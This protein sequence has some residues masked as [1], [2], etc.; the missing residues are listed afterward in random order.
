VD[1][2]SLIYP[3]WVDFAPLY[4]KA[5]AIAHAYD[6][7]NLVFFLGSGISK[8]YAEEMPNWEQLLNILLNKLRLKTR[9]QREEVLSLLGQ[10]KYLVAAEAIKRYAITDVSNRDVAVDQAIAE[11]LQQRLKRSPN[12]NP[13]V[14]LTLMDFSVP[15]FTT[16]YDTIVEDI[17]AEHNVDTYSRVAI[18]YEDETAAGQ[19][20]SPTQKSENFVFKLHGSIGKPGRL[21]FDE[22]DYFDFYFQ[23]KW[24]ISLELL[25]HTLATKMV[26][27]IGFSLSDPEIMLILREATRYSSSYQHVALMLE[28]EVNPIEREILRS[29]YKVDP[30]LYNDHSLLPLFVMEMR[31]FYRQ[32]GI[33]FRIKPEAANLKKAVEV[34]KKQNL[35]VDHCAVLVFGS[36][37]K[38]GSF[39]NPEADVD[40]LFL[41]K[42][43]LKEPRIKNPDADQVLGKRVDATVMKFSEFEK[44]LTMGDPFASSVLLTGCPLEDPAGRYGILSRGFQGD[45]SYSEILK[46]AEERYSLRWLRFCIYKSARL[47]EYLQACYQWSITLMQLFIIKDDYQLDQLLAISLL[48]N[49]R[50][51][52]HQFAIRFEDVDERFYLALLQAVKRPN[53]AKQMSRPNI[54]DMIRQFVHALKSRFQNGQLAMLRPGSFLKKKKVSTILKKYE[55]VAQLIDVMNRGETKISLGYGISDVES[56]FLKVFDGEDVT[57][58][59]Y[60][61]F[62]ELHKLV[63]YRSNSGAIDEEDLLEICRHAT[64]KWRESPGA[65]FLEN[66]S[67]NR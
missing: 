45:Y 4:Q 2:G 25:S 11:I 28:S 15:I 32:E 29:N 49:P 51:V 42:Y 37:A 40:V 57:A 26:V 62:I 3:Y 7:R 56:D 43:Y 1:E 33:P 36:F 52:I 53:H 39:A 5:D 9:S 17:I 61:F 8:V 34:I 31:S 50:F 65:S 20:L 12:K 67:R 21:I 14:H 41:P 35:N 30:I 23:K 18:T 22:Q 60:L 54:D 27:F 55:A 10:G 24:P 19:L 59:D 47:D 58:F 46:N 38:Y 63:T 44:R 13:L 6:S 48:G 16:N 66:L 64:L